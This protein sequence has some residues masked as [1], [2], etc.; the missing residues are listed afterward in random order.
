[1]GFGSAGS[2]RP[3]AEHLSASLHA[4]PHP[5]NA[6]EVW[7]TRSA[8]VSA[9][10]S[11]G[12][13]AA[14]LRSA[15][16][17]AASTVAAPERFNKNSRRL[18]RSPCRPACGRLNSRCRIAHHRPSERAEGRRPHAGAFPAPQLGRTHQD[19]RTLVAAVENH[20]R[21]RLPAGAK[22]IR[23]LGPAGEGELSS[24]ALHGAALGR[25]PPT[26]GAVAPSQVYAGGRTKPPISAASSRANA[27]VVGSSPSGPMICR[28]TGN[29]SAVK[30]IGA[31]VAGR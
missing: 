25:A 3:S 12:P 22:G 13:G 6:L 20:V 29:P 8:L 30:P 11:R 1:V 31:A 14:A 21:A 2:R 19:R 17:G 4:A 9:T 26:P 24:R 7:F 15:R 10:I 28:P 16:G 27:I 5:G 18:I 23:T